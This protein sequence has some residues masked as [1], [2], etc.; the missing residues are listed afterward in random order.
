MKRPSSQDADPRPFLA[1]C[2]C[3]RY[4]VQRTDT[5]TVSVQR[6]VS[7]NET[8]R[9]CCSHRTREREREEERVGKGRAEPRRPAPARARARERARKKNSAGADQGSMFLPPVIAPETAPKERGRGGDHTT[10]APWPSA[11]LLRYRDSYCSRDPARTS[12][13][14]SPSAMNGLVSTCWSMRE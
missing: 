10:R 2:S 5:R 4:G 9:C 11:S 3:A 7:P 8:G 12:F 13:A 1:A 14:L 6:W